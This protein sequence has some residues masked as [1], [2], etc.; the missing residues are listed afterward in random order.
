M[1]EAP[2]VRLA[3]QHIKSTDLVG[4]RVWLRGWE[5]KSATFPYAIIDLIDDVNPVQQGDAQNY[6]Q[7]GQ[8]IQVSVFQ[9]ALIKGADG[10]L[11]KVYD[12]LLPGNL[13]RSFMNMPKEY[14]E[15]ESLVRF[16]HRL[17]GINDLPQP[18]EELVRQTSFTINVTLPLAA[19]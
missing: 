9:K 16:T 12:G 2:I 18:D 15:G 4:G 5:P 11:Q 7:W 1:A 19:I 14:G 13:F 3:I 8:T 10:Q 6:S 17:G